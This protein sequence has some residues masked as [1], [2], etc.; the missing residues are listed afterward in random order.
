MARAA[1]ASSS[2]PVSTECVAGSAA[3]ENELSPLFAQAVR[4]RDKGL[5]VHVAFPCTAVR[6][7]PAEVLAVVVA[8]HG[9]HARVVGIQSLGS[10]T[11]RARV[12]RVSTGGGPNHA[13]T[14]AVEFFRTDLPASSVTDL[15]DRMRTALAAR[16]TTEQR[17]PEAGAIELGPVG[18]SSANISLEIELRDTLGAVSRRAWQGYEGSLDAAN[19]VPVEYAWRALGKAAIES[20]AV[21]GPEP[22]D[23]ALLSAAWLHG[24]GSFERPWYALRALLILA[25]R[26]GS[27]ELIPAI[28]KQ[29][30]SEDTE[31][32]RLAVD[33]LA[34]ITGRDVR[35]EASGGE[36]T[37]GDLV[38]DYRREC[39]AP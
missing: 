6:A 11:F 25:G 13:A 4:D 28:V 9:G 35:H 22:E 36:R 23:R 26:A 8:G 21:Q 33:A 34:A 27:P 2:P 16:V 38:A 12:L 10:R 1:Q 31:V 20:T 7:Q 39:T 17:P 3:L 30:D 5:L 24:V 19:R 32:Q 15:F 18:I 29:L 37:L 14:G